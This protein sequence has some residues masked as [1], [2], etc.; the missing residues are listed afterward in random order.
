[1]IEFLFLVASIQSTLFHSTSPTSTAAHLIERSRLLVNPKRRQKGSG[2]DKYLET[3][4]VNGNFYGE[5]CWRPHSRGSPVP[6][7]FRR[8]EG[9]E[10]WFRDC[11]HA[12][13]RCSLFTRPMT[14][15]G[16][17]ENDKIFPQRILNAWFAVLIMYNSCEAIVSV[18]Y[19]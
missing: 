18:S 11:K 12:I 5:K 15:M 19:L 13:S 3:F 10:K 2:S 14:E 6:H 4:K 1:M 17:M 7:G 16:H 9:N 8:S